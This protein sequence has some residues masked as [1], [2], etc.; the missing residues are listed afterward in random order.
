MTQC[1]TTV[2]FVCIAAAAPRPIPYTLPTVT[3]ENY[4]LFNGYAHLSAGLSTGLCGLAAGMA[5]G[6]VGDAG[7]L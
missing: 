5:I 2:P 4:T 7:M 3:D 6:I 1:L